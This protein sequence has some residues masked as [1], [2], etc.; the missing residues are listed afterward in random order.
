MKKSLKNPYRESDPKHRAW[1]D[2]F[3]APQTNNPYLEGDCDPRIRNAWW[4][5]RDAKALSVVVTERNVV[6]E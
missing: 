6:S 5:G 2:G 1:E 3:K 4:L